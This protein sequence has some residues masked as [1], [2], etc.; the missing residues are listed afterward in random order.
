MFCIGITISINRIFWGTSIEKDIFLPGMPMEVNK[1][2]NM[3]FFTY[4]S[5]L[6]FK[7]INFRMHFARTTFPFSI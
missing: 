5:Y 1:H 6:L 2:K 7:I 4:L 3:F